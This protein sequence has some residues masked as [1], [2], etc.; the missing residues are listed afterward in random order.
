MYDSA[1]FYAMLTKSVNRDFNLRLAVQLSEEASNKLAPEYRISDAEP[2][3][4]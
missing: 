1:S 3:K 4:L 2:A